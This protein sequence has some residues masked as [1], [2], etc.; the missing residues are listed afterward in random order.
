MSGI[1]QWVLVKFKKLQGTGMRL[2]VGV[3]AHQSLVVPEIL[4][5]VAIGNKLCDERQ[6]LLDCHTANH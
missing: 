4:E 3:R 1:M 5:E 2:S 6:R